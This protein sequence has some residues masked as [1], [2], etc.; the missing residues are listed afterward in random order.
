MSWLTQLYYRSPLNLNSFLAKVLPFHKY[1]F[2]DK[3]PKHVRELHKL[4]SEFP[5]LSKSIQIENAEANSFLINWCQQMD[6]S[7][8]RAVVFLDPY[9]M[10][11][12]WELLQAIANT[13]AIDL[14]LLFPL[15]VGVNRLLTREKFPEKSWADA[16]TR[17]FGTEDWR[18]F[19]KP[20]SQPSLY[21]ESTTECKSVDFEQIGNFFINRLETIFPEVVKKPLQLCNSRNNPLY[22]FCFA[23]ANK[24]AIKIAG[25]IIGKTKRS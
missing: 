17:I 4:K 8:N 2:L 12:N 10:Q 5:K 18:S 25:D 24:T 9:G 1:L 16:L 13:K 14:W 19:Y 7:K 11:V 23:A 3:L 20:S 6:W 15:G 22:L 21:G